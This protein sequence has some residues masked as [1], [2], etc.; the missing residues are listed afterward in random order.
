MPSNK[1]VNQVINI[2]W[3]KKYKIRRS[4]TLRTPCAL[5]GHGIEPGNRYFDGGVNCRAHYGCVLIIEEKLCYWEPTAEDILASKDK[6]IED[7]TQH[8]KRL[9]RR[10]QAIEEK[11]LEARRVIKSMTRE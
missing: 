2:D 8:N 4:R 11:L 3:R 6:H 5:C 9:T 1:T 10:L 7:V